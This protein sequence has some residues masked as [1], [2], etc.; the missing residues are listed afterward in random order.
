MVGGA[1]DMT[2]NSVLH[3]C[4]CMLGTFNHIKAFSQFTSYFHNLKLEKKFLLDGNFSQLNLVSYFSTFNGSFAQVNS[5]P[6]FT[7]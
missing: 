5:V 2:Q 7:R 3:A 4:E 1:A 6:A